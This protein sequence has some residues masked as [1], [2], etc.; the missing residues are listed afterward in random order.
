MMEDL[1]EDSSQS[2]RDIQIPPHLHMHLH[3]HVHAYTPILYIDTHVYIIHMCTHI[4]RPSVTH[5]THTTNT[6]QHT[7][8]HII[9]IDTNVHTYITDMH[10]QSCVHRHMYYNKTHLT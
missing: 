3:M 6:T 10:T 4:Y 9:H 5:T 1:H 7:C 2:S 8:M